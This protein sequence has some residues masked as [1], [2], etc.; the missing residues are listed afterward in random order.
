MDSWSAMADPT[1]RKILELLSKGDLSAGEI[2]DNF[3]MAKPSISHHLSVL[4]NAGLIDG[5]KK[6]Q[7]IIYTLNT[8]VFEEILLLFRNLMKSRK[9]E[10]FDEE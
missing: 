6:G 5:E 1:R 10:N 2:A 9:E 4:K 7:N 3:D 8:S